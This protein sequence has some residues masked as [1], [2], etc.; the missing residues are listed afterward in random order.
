MIKEL[1]CKKCAM[2]HTEVQKKIG[3]NKKENIYFALWYHH[4]T[5]YSTDQTNAI[6]QE[7]ATIAYPLY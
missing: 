7:L 6:I 4:F 5:T 1:Y 2:M 3:E